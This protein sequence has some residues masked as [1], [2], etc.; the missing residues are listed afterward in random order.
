VTG[1]EVRAAEPAID[2]EQLDA[3]GTAA[4][5][6]PPRVGQ[7][8]IPFAARDERAELLEPTPH[9]LIADERRLLPL[10][11]RE[12]KLDSRLRPLRELFEDLP[13]QP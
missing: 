7:R 2:P 8:D 1:P 4:Q 3:V 5:H 6:P 13:L 9:D 12:E 11:N 10:L